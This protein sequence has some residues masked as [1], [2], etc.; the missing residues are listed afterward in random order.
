MERDK[1]IGGGKTGGFYEVLP[2]IWNAPVSDHLMHGYE[3]RQDFRLA[4]RQIVNRWKV[5]V[6]ECVGERHGFLLLRFHDTPGGEPDEE[7]IPEYL[8]QEAG[9]PEC[10]GQPDAAD[11]GLDA[12]FGFD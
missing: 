12:L 7:W 8:L 5:R 6:G 1:T 9:A 2:G 3:S 4:V 10:A 11:D